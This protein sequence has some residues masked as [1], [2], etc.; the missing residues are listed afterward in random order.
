MTFS[1][2]RATS[3]STMPT[4]AQTIQDG[5]YEP[6]TFLEGAPSQPATRAA[7][8]SHGMCL[9]TLISLSLAAESLEKTPPFG[10]LLIDS[11]FF[12]GCPGK[13]N[14]LRTETSY[15]FP[16]GMAS[17]VSGCSCMTEL[18]LGLLATVTFGVMVVMLIAA[19]T[20]HKLRR[21]NAVRTSS[22]LSELVWSAIPWLIFIAAATP[23]V[24][25]II[26]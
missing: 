1:T 2:A 25:S 18:I 7:K 5:K 19:C 11:R 10:G 22:L 20:S 24:I 21:D 12:Q 14:P 16:P 3:A 15:I 4:R 9:E 8:H 26:R 13:C 17:P 6:R 23:S